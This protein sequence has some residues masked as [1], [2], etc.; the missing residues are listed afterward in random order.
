[1]TRKHTALRRAVWILAAAYLA[2]P[3]VAALLRYPD[4][5][6]PRIYPEIYHGAVF[7]LVYVMCYGQKPRYS[8]MYERAWFYG[9]ERP[10]DEELVRRTA[11]RKWFPGIKN[12][13]PIVPVLPDGF[14]AGYPTEPV[15]G[16]GKR[17]LLWATPEVI[18]K[19][20]HEPAGAPCFMVSENFHQDNN[21]PDL[22]AD[23]KTF[24]AEM[25]E[26]GHAV[27][28]CDVGIIDGWPM[29]WASV[30]SEGI[31]ASWVT[32]YHPEGKSSVEIGLLGGDRGTGIWDEFIAPIRQR[33]REFTPE[34]RT[35]FAPP[36]PLL[37]SGNTDPFAED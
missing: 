31:P 14:V 27:V 33:M 37:P 3:V 1:M 28:G 29:I 21:R 2:G 25:E 9:M 12:P 6:G 24:A 23:G 8:R 5:R 20:P 7:H 30:V 10:L 32:F 4:R 17:R 22:L 13:P 35:R 18:G 16:D 34:E 36:P 11:F 26:T 15:F 19:M